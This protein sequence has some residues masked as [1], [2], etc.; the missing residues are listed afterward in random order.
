MAMAKHCF[1]IAR[2]GTP[3]NKRLKGLISMAS[4]FAKGST[5]HNRTIPRARA[6]VVCRRTISDEKCEGA[7]GP[8]QVCASAREVTD[9]DGQN[10]TALKLANLLWFLLWL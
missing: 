4:P 7:F 9:A 5:N 1:N 6:R 10:H 2:S 3:A 8:H